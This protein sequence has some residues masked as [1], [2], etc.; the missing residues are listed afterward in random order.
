VQYRHAL[1]SATKK[2]SPMSHIV[3]NTIFIFFIAPS[4]DMEKNI[5]M[6]F[7]AFINTNTYIVGKRKA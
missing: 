3:F 6:T 1:P 5:A 2:N 4:R 7:F